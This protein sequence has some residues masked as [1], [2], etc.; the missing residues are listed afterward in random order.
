M[1][2]AESNL[3]H[4]ISRTAT[5]DTSGASKQEVLVDFHELLCPEVL[6][7]EYVGRVDLRGHA[8]GEIF[9]SLAPIA[10][11]YGRVVAVGF[12]IGLLEEREP[13]LVWVLALG[14]VL[15]QPHQF[16][17]QADRGRGFAMA[18]SPVH[19]CWTGRS[20]GTL[21]QN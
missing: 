2:T 3:S 19:H 9:D 18:C 14:K 20:F 16:P 1:V 21:P 8:A 11:F 10:A 5:P 15:E 4:K 6:L 7:I 12:G 13:R 17:I